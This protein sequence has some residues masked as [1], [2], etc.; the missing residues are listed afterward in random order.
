MLSLRAKTNS[1]LYL[2]PDRLCL[3]RVVPV[4]RDV[5]PVR[6]PEETQTDPQPAQVPLH[7][8]PQRSVWER[9]GWV[10]PV[11]IIALSCSAAGPGKKGLGFSVVGG[12][13]SPKG[14]MG[15]FVKT[16]FPVGQAADE[17]SLREGEWW[18]W[19]SAHITS[20]CFRWRDPLG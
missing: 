6:T 13:D 17:G 19:L 4:E 10:S 16:I 8:S 14:S 7:V 9:W 5:C 12:I 18:W 11:I 2:R 1:P 15:I 3:H 20:G